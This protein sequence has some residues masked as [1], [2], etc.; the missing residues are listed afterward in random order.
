MKLAGHYLAHRKSG[1]GG[2]PDAGK[3]EAALERC[4]A[5][6]REA[7]PE[8][9]LSEVEFVRH[10]AQR[11]GSLE[12][13]L[14]HAPDLH[15]ACACAAGSADAV[16]AFE[17]RYLSKVPAFVASVVRGPAAEEVCQRVRERLLVGQDGAP[18]RI[19]EY[20][21]RGPLESWLR[22]AAVRIALNLEREER[23]RRNATAAAAD[24]AIPTPADPELDYLRSRYR[25]EIEDAL[26]AAVGT[27]PVRERTI[28]R[29]HYL[30]RARIGAIAASYGVHRATVSRWVAAAQEALL[31]ETRRLLR[32]R[33]R[34]TPTECESFLGLVR[35][36][37]DVTLSSCL[38][39]R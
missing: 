39:S 28:L 30:E 38:G 24:E 26:R 33:L 19:A 7:W 9:A 10:L 15:L 32:E 27:L 8:V 14:A 23:R 21:G 34:L 29:L 16:A 11:C 18:G 1:A 25:P 31:D 36:R 2:A 12:D 35:S 6:A 17:A 22:A 20:T 37:L 13:A 4:T 5:A 3:L